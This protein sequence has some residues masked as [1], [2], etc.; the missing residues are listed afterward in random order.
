MK[1]NFLQKLLPPEEKIFFTI[2]EESSKK[3]NEVAKLYYDIVHSSISKG[4]EKNNITEECVR[5]VKRIKTESNEVSKQLLIKLNQTF[6]TPI[7]REDIQLINSLMSKITKR[8][9]KASFNLEVYRLTE[10]NDYMKTQAHALIRAAEELNTCVGLLRH[11]KSNQLKLVSES[12]NRM[13]EIESEGDEIL[14]KAIDDVFSGKY[15]AL[16]VIKLRDIYKD[17]ENAMDTCFSVSDTIVN[18]VL[19]HG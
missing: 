3:C 9:V 17:I 5:N 13:R 14:H 1:Q 19:K 2:F 15:D 11:I 10:F 12:N 8:I 6:I 4:N 7:D 18:V 16:T